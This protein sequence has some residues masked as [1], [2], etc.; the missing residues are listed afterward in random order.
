MEVNLNPKGLQQ[1]VIFNIIYFFC[2]RGRE[3]LYSMIQDT[4]KI[5]VELDGT[6]FIV[7]ANDELDKNHGVEGFEAHHIIALSS[8]KSESTMKEYSIRCPDKKRKEMF[9]SLSSAL[10]SKKVSKP[11][12]QQL[13]L[14]RV[15]C[16]LTWWTLKLT[17]LLFDD[18]DTIDDATL[19]AILNDFDKTTGPPTN[20]KPNKNTPTDNQTIQNTTQTTKQN[21]KTT[22]ANGPQV[23]IPPLQLQTQNQINTTNNTQAFPRPAP[24]Y[25]PH[26]NVTINYHINQ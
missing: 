3:N 2:R 8:H 12:K 19:Y 11:L 15:H 16:P 9:D 22:M 17:F 14:L 25:F 23:P 10:K 5:I 26:N 18:F 1:Q 7:H 21:Q 4:F 6:E 24:M 13:N 20:A